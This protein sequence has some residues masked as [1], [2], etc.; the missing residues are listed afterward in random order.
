LGSARAMEP[1]A[2]EEPGQQLW[3]ARVADGGRLTDW[4]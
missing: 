3:I 1:L 2:G 4:G